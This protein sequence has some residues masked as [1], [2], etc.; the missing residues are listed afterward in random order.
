MLLV[1]LVS[2]LF[3]N[4]V[5]GQCDNTQDIECKGWGDP[6]ITTFDGLYYHFMGVGYYDYVAPCEDSD[7]F[8]FLITAKQYLCS[9]VYT[10]IGEVIVT[11]DDGSGTAI[12]YSSDDTADR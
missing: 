12:V 5:K 11:I 6:H 4:A 3:L 9:G 2:L 1:G 7:Y 8:P 10:C